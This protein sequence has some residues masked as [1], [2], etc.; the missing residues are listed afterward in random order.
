MVADDLEHVSFARKCR[1][2][3]FRRSSSPS[4]SLSVSR[5]EIKELLVWPP[6]QG[7]LTSAGSHHKIWAVSERSCTAFASFDRRSRF[8]P[9]DLSAVSGIA[10]WAEAKSCSGSNHC[11]CQ[12]S[13]SRN[14]PIQNHTGLFTYGTRFF[15]GRLATMM[16]GLPFASLAMYHSISKQNAKQMAVS[17][18]A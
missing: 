9:Y 14:W 6:I 1:L 8:A 18:S 7:A 16:F 4:G 3:Q 15:A 5:T 2:C 11:G 12:T 17:I 13:S 10:L